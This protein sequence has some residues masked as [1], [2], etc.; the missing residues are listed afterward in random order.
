MKCGKKIQ[1]TEV[2]FHQMCNKKEKFDKIKC[3]NSMYF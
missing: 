1:V 2:L 3:L